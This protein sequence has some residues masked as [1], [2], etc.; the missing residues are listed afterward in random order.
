M[1]ILMRH[2]NIRDYFDR[3]R[4][5]SVTILKFWYINRLGWLFI[6]HSFLVTLFIIHSNQNNYYPNIKLF[7]LTSI[8]NN[9]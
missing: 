7:A 2:F 3:R 1:T 6:I 5:L 9:F 4:S 8:K